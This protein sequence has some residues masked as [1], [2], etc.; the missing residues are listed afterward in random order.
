MTTDAAGL[1]LALVATRLAAR[2]PS[3]TRTF[4]LQRAEVLAALANGAIVLVV[5]A[6]V[7]VEGVQRLLAP[8]P[9]A[10]VPMLV[11]AGAG[12]VANAVG[13]VALRAG[14]R[15][16][17]NLRGAYLEVMGDA[18]GSVAVIA[19]GIVV[20]STGWQRAD[21]VAS[22]V[23]GALIVPRAFSLLKEVVHVLL[24]GTPREVDL[25]G[26]RRHIEAL[27]GVVGTHDLHAWTITSGVPALTAHV[28]VAPDVVQP[29]RYHDLLDSLRDCLAGHFDLSHS[30]FQIE[31]ANHTD[32][33]PAHP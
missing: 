20:M 1:A 11:A 25:A 17:L 4:G 19:A 21:A 10:A 14:A 32:A 8:S 22:I 30:T 31:P 2:P 18:L 26:V 6:T 7:L 16:S 12:L 33:G 24:E 3:P 15:Q 13:L 23:I 9:V 27:P 29:Q 5:G 28:V